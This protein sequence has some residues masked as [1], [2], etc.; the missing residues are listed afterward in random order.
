MSGGVCSYIKM[1]QHIKLRMIAFPKDDSAGLRYRFEFME[2][3]TYRPHFS[4]TSDAR[5]L[6]TRASFH[7]AMLELLDTHSLDQITIPDI[8]FAARIGRTSFF[9]HYP[10]KEALLEEVATGEIRQL[11]NL[12][13]AVFDSS[14]SEQ[15]S[16]AIFSYVAKR[17]TLWITL[18][19]GGAAAAL[20]EEFIRLSQ[21][22]TAKTEQK[23]EWLPADAGIIL[24]VSGTVELLTWWLRQKRPI[25]IKKVAKIF[26]RAVFSPIFEP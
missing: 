5:V 9:R 11:V 14:D 17:R 4:S 16:L 19:T 20:K 25:S 18:L 10:S 13:L 2:K 3:K 7:A 22:V 21:E 23:S 24:V 12:S 6:R 1:R 15:A 26:E 8:T